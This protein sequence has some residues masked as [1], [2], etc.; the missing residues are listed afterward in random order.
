MPLRA[1]DDVLTHS[2][3]APV[4]RSDAMRSFTRPKGTSQGEAVITHEVRITFRRDGTH[5]SKNEKAVRLDCF[6]FCAILTKW[7]SITINYIIVPLFP[8][9][10]PSARDPCRMLALKIR[11][12]NN[13]A[14]GRK[15][16]QKSDCRCIRFP[17]SF[18][19]NLPTEDFP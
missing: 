2:D 1:S 5:R 18:A 10:Y 13:R 14:N 9:T 15:R 19:L 16:I 7:M 6:R 11:E 3:V 12:S 8:Q 17:S 4:G